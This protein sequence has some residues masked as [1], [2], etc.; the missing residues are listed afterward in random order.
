MK[1]YPIAMMIALLLACGGWSQTV[2]L[3]AEV[4][5]EPG[6]FVKV[7]AELPDGGKEVRWY[8][9]DKGLQVFPV[10]LLKDSK[11]AVVIANAPGRY[12]LV[13]WTA[14]GDVP[15]DPAV[16]VVIVGDVPPVPPDP[17]PGPKPPDPQPASVKRVLI[18][19]ESAEASKMPEKQQQ[20]LYGKTVRD[21]LN[22]HCEPDADGK[23][24]A[25]RIWDKDVDASS[26][27]KHWQDVMKVQR[28]AVPWL[29]IGDG[30]TGYS[31]PLPATV[32]EFLTLARKHLGE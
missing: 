16:C 2:K 28:S 29:V 15:S 19:F 6:A 26:E 7:P 13:A 9:P 20:I 10:E 11:T 5:A 12:R 30:K 17:G 27:S 21:Y 8:S 22:S 23:T 18:V 31:G 24:K 3:P 4:K 32:E 25:F 14:K 1:R